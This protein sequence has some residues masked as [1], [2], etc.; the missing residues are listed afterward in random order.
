MRRKNLL[1]LILSLLSPGQVR[2]L[3]AKFAEGTMTIAE[4][5]RRSLCPPVLLYCILTPLWSKTPVKLRL[6]RVEKQVVL[7]K[8]QKLSESKIA[9]QLK[10]P[11]SVVREHG[12]RQFSERVTAERPWYHLR[13]PRPKDPDILEYE[14]STLPPTLRIGWQDGMLMDIPA[15]RKGVCPTCHH[16]VAMPCLACRVRA[17]M[18]TRTIPRAEEYEDAEESDGLEP[19]LLFR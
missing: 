5:S 10:L 1:D 2:N 16:L 4:L 17:D 19:D 12:S 18:A 13:A 11:L 6:L 8:R 3:R 7:L 14:E 15:A 9:G